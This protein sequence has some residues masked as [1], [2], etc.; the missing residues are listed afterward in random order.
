MQEYCH[1]QKNMRAM[2]HLNH[3]AIRLY[4]AQQPFQSYLLERESIS[5]LKEEHESFIHFRIYVVN[6]VDNILYETK[7]VV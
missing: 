3:V 7:L 5:F 2:F 4:K 1:I 6:I